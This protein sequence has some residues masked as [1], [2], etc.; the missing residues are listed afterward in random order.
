[1]EL[2]HSFAPFYAKGPYPDYSKRMAEL[3]P[4]ILNKFNTHPSTILDMACGEGAF[5][6]AMA[7]CGFKVTGVDLSLAMLQIAQE[8]AKEEQ[9][10]IKL[11]N[12][13]IRTLSISE[14]FDLVTCWYDSL[15]YLLTTED[16]RN[17]FCG[18]ARGLRDGGLFIFDLN[19]IYALSVIWQRNPSVIEQDTPT[20][21]EIHQMTYDS[22]R[23][24]ATMHITG[25][26]KKEE[27]W[28]RFDETHVVH[29]FTIEE[30]RECINQ[31]GLKEM[32]CWGDIRNMTEP[33]PDSGK[34]WFVTQKD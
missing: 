10:E 9:V 8:R 28:S 23:D 5:A 33:K 11:I 19:T 13:D 29:G 15:N 26:L 2:Y 34:V 18:A 31:A 12:Q 14:E 7:K 20:M 22:E 27:F 25:F 24:N 21:L 16:L 17:A 6:I 32:A 30:I 3:L 4:E 1:M